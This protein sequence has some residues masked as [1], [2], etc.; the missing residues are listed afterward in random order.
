MAKPKGR[1][2]QQK[3]KLK[4]GLVL[5]TGAGVLAVLIA[6]MVILAGTP[7]VEAAPA[8]E[9]TTIDGER[10]A[11][12][13][14]RGDVYAVDFFFTWCQICARQYPAKQELVE[15][16]ADRP[17]F[18]FISISA[19]PTDTPEVL[20]QYRR[21][22]GAS[23][24]FVSDAFGLY[25]KFEVSGRPF[26]VFVDR[27][28]NVIDTIRRITPANELIAIAQELLDK[29]M[30]PTGESNATA[31]ASFVLLAVPARFASRSLQ[32]PA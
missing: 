21:S 27:D 30:T 6:A 19:D 28:G 7:T 22:H 12:G 15:H 13:E 10:L 2:A 18:H 4:T 20:D 5:G 31:A 26:I 8:W 17:D 24:P 23:W 14:L 1:K 3:G 9:A 11:S 32:V 25:Q 16:F 29:P